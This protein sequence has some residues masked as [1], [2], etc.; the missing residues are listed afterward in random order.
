MQQKPLKNL[1]GLITLV[2]ASC[3]MIWLRFVDFET[4]SPWLLTLGR[5]HPIIL[6][7]PL[8]LLLLLLIVQALQVFKVLNLPGLLIEYLFVATILLTGLTFLSGF[9]LYANGEYSGF[10]IDQHFNGA[11]ITFLLLALSFLL[12]QRKENNRIF[13]NLALL[14][15][16]GSNGF[17]LFTGHQG[18]SLTHGRNFLTEYVPMITQPEEVEAMHRDSLEFLYEDMIQ[19]ILES[20][21]AGCHS[22]LRSKGGLSVSS[23]QDLFKKGESGKIPVIHSAADSSELYRRLILPDSLDEH[24]PP[25]G[26]TP[27]DRKEI[28]LIK[29]W[30]DAGANENMSLAD[31]PDSITN[32]LVTPLSTAIRKYNFDMTRSRLSQ[33]KIEEEL[34]ALSAYLEMVVKPDS[35]SEGSLF[36]LSNKFP[37]VTF[38]TKK[39]LE[40]KPYLD[41]FSKVSVASSDIDDADLYFFGNMT[42]LKEL[43]LQK[44]K[45]KGQGLVYLSK[46]PHL[47]VLNLSFTGTDD[48]M[49]LELMQFPALK[50]VY[51]YGTQ[52][53]YP[54]IQAVKAYKPELKIHTEEG[55]YF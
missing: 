29:Y 37:P 8:A 36:M 39:L 7:F 41:M 18:G 11:L 40:L 50:E 26:K 10:L 14:A 49:L 25:A 51:L 38:T 22:T 55:P 28:Q 20:K 2:L 1:W 6:H 44:T 43:Y 34:T 16:L 5:F 9:L 4:Q 24:M 21:C 30:I 52:V 54:V 15:L 17:A 12:F 53:S 3:L 35:L 47:E 46:L 31:V 33:E 48:K 27:L 19:P 13:N 23:L 45:V 42:N 32:M